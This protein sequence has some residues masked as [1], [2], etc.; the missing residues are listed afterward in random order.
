MFKKLRDRIS[1]EVQQQ[2]LKLPASVQQL[3][4]QS[5]LDLSGRD[6]SAAANNVNL[7]TIDDESPTK[8]F[9]VNVNPKRTG[10]LHDV[11][12]DSTSAGHSPAGWP[13]VSARFHRGSVGSS[14]S[15]IPACSSPLPMGDVPSANFTIPLSDL[16]SASEWEESYAADGITKDRLFQAYSKMRQRYHKYKGRYADVVRAYR[17]KEREA[18]KLRD[19]LAKTQDQTM[20]RISDLRD[21]CALETQAKAHLEE[22]LRGDLE[23]KDHKIQS[24]LTKVRLL[25]E[26]Y[27]LHREEDTSN[28][29]KYDEVMN[30][31]G[32]RGGDA[33]DGTCKSLGSHDSGVA[34]GVWDDP[35]F[36]GPGA[37]D[38][39]GDRRATCL[40][41][42]NVSLGSVSMS[43]A[44]STTGST[45]SQL[46]AEE[47]IEKLKGE[48]SQQKQ[49]LARCMEN[50]RNKRD[51][52]AAVTA[53]RN[54]L[55]AKLAAVQNEHQIELDQLKQT[56]ES[57]ALS[58]AETKQ[59]LF[60]EL[61]RKE[62]QVEELRE[63]CAEL[64]QK[65]DQ[66]PPPRP[67]PDGCSSLPATPVLNADE[68]TA[69][70]EKQAIRLAVGLCPEV[71]PPSS[72]LVAVPSLEHSSLGHPSL[73]HPSLVQPLDENQSLV[74]QTEILPCEEQQSSQT[75]PLPSS[76]DLLTFSEAIDQ[77]SST[78]NDVQTTYVAAIAEL[79]TTKRDLQWRIGEL[80]EK[81]RQSEEL[82][83]Q[84]TDDCAEMETKYSNVQ[85]RNERLQAELDSLNASY[86]EVQGSVNE[87]VKQRSELSN[88]VSCLL[89]E[90][91]LLK[92]TTEQHERSKSES[93][94]LAEQIETLKDSH[95]RLECELLAIKTEREKLQRDLLEAI[96]ERDEIRG[97]ASFTLTCLQELSS[98]LDDELLVGGK[99]LNTE[100]TVDSKREIVYSSEAFDVRQ[101]CDN[102]KQRIHDQHS[103]LEK[104][105]SDKCDA[106]KRVSVLQN[107]C[108]S[109]MAEADSIINDRRELQAK[110][111]HVENEFDS[112]RQRCEVLEEQA[113]KSLEIRSNVEQQITHLNSN[114]KLLEAERSEK[115]AEIEGLREQLEITS[116]NLVDASRKNDELHTIQEN[117]KIVNEALTTEKASLS[118]SLSDVL[119]ER[120]EWKS[121]CTSL[122][123]E[124]D[125]KQRRV[126]ELDKLL[127]QSN[128]ALSVSMEKTDKLS[129]ENDNLNT[130]LIELED[131]HER[132][133][134]STQSA[135]DLE[136]NAELLRAEISQKNSDLSQMEE[137][138]AFRE[139]EISELMSS[140]D[141]LISTKQVLADRIKSLE[142]DLEA[143]KSLELE[144]KHEMNLLNEQLETVTNL[145]T[146]ALDAEGRINELET[147]CA[148]RVADLEQLLND[149]KERTN[150]L[151]DELK[152]SS[153][154]I[155][156]LE[157]ELEILKI[158][159]DSQVV[160]LERL[161]MDSERVAELEQLNNESSARVVE[162]ESELEV[163]K[164][165]SDSRAKELQNELEQANMDSNSKFTELEQLKIESSTRVVELERELEVVKRTSDS[166]VTELQ[167]EL[168]QVKKEMSIS[169]TELD[170]LK[171]NSDSRVAQ[172]E[173]EKERIKHTHDLQ[174]KELEQRLAT[175]DDRL[176]DLGK[177]MQRLKDAHDV[178][179]ADMEQL[180]RTSDLR[181]MEVENQLL[182]CKQEL[183]ASKLELSQKTELLA[184]KEDEWRVD[185]TDLRAK[186]EEKSNEVQ[187]LNQ[188]MD[189]RITD[190]EN[191]VKALLTQHEYLN[192]ELS[193]SKQ[194]VEELRKNLNS[195]EK[196]LTEANSLN[197]SHSDEHRQLLNT[198][199]EKEQLI[200]T[201]REENQNLWT[202]SQA[203]MKAVS[204]ELEQQK[205][206]MQA[207]S[208][209]LEEKILGLETNS[210]EN[211]ALSEHQIASL[212]A[213]VKE[214]EGRLSLQ[215]LE[216]E[217][218][219]QKHAELLQHQDQQLLQQ[220]QLQEQQQVSGAGR[221]SDGVDVSAEQRSQLENTRSS[222]PDIAAMR[223]E[224]LQLKGMIAK[225]E[226]ERENSVK[227]VAMLQFNNEHNKN[228]VFNMELSYAQLSEK[229]KALQEKLDSRDKST[230]ELNYD[231]RVK[232]LE[233][234]HAFDKE[235]VQTQFLELQKK[236]E[237][238]F[239]AEK[240]EL[241]KKYKETVKRL[242]EEVAGLQEIKESYAKQ[243]QQIEENNAAMHGKLSAVQDARDLAR[244]EKQK[245]EDRLSELSKEKDQIQ[246]EFDELSKLKVK[247]EH[248]LNDE[249][250]KVGR[251]D[252]RLVQLTKENNELQS[253]I[254]KLSHCQ[255]TVSG[256]V[257][258]LAKSEE[259]LN[260][261]CELL[262]ENL[263]IAREEAS[264]AEA[265]ST[266]ERDR[267]QDEINRLKDQLEA[268]G[269][270]MS[271][272]QAKEEAM[273]KL[274]TELKLKNE[275]LISRVAEERRSQSEELE[276]L[277]QSLAAK[278]DARASAQ[279]AEESWDEVTADAQT[280]PGDASDVDNA[281]QNSLPSGSEGSVKRDIE[282]LLSHVEG[283]WRTRTAQ[284]V[285]RKEQQLRR[286][287]EQLEQEWNKEKKELERLTGVAAQAFRTG[288]D[289]VE[290]LRQQVEQ[291]RQELQHIKRQHKL[292]VGELRALLE[293]K[294]RGKK[295]D[296]SGTSATAALEDSA[297]FEYLK[298]VLYQY[299]MG[300]ETQTLARVL[301]AVVK[302][303]EQQQ[304]DIASHLQSLTSMRGA[305]SSGSGTD[306]SR[307]TNFSDDS[308]PP[309]IPPKKR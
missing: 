275:D 29:N 161:K 292:E 43:A 233:E 270:Q 263:R 97:A 153:L 269:N 68:E 309:P 298:N 219:Q 212:E 118:S 265:R 259:D 189:Q 185:V 251:L 120:D 98:S 109:L 260:G 252:E 66:P 274:E 215:Q 88:R 156:E 123:N 122:Q 65:L 142:N 99:V 13:P 132:L 102:L 35:S 137:Q 278:Y 262:R 188:E 202:K 198:L 8:D 93:S 141:E 5:L 296:A 126:L 60:E 22:E 283:A 242:E 183:N 229:V 52:V 34:A 12:L 243:V 27:G 155:A 267:M 39:G 216:Y 84:L 48:V 217:Q 41:V 24:L 182:H 11:Q 200:V 40:E 240:A 51:V 31:A 154:R 76:G 112:C 228:K 255:D 140:R 70:L 75:E 1:E 308:K 256:E 303:D 23:E 69:A 271:C 168:E 20:R 224:Q 59:Q 121:K 117:L 273:Q 170:K 232:D 299:M 186:L 147:S 305:R 110:L 124:N 295:S 209:E 86:H 300:R 222:S 220:Q 250:M 277:L 36:P 282:S 6:A 167:K 164:R 47:L 87:H 17:E 159:R 138:A 146:R 79:E 111:E 2:S 71:S 106:E 173:E 214:Y 160:E 57:S 148:T 293:V 114:L 58:M 287:M 28:N 37:Y 247:F 32:G 230:E 139:K 226:E 221:T 115:S 149:S 127:D 213:Q 289:S 191:Q 16:E 151:E 4:Q 55:A 201:L 103:T 258:S 244:A 187:N 129:S 290:L 38:E 33:A 163:L 7:F 172:L 304:Q 85:N 74:G 63:Q 241:E 135:S 276:R 225:Y 89:E 56:I 19:V 266:L 199:S 204:Q 208:R 196:N 53:E 50:I 144:L 64:Q 249:R 145:E 113:T 207:A 9:G 45:Y 62:E 184:K 231:Q 107:Q 136:Q 130:R 104:L 301:C 237:E 162:L 78:S 238:V 128:S 105:Q 25:Q 174:V 253:K 175:S 264:T 281:A 179:L 158:T 116:Q 193:T 119:T 46:Q 284:L 285:L 236:S 101:Y 108:D 181:V 83:R 54:G 171:L 239:L 125:E 254:R 306:A 190:H 80:E 3:T 152:N 197:S 302:F 82:V 307:S 294:K 92:E 49:L 96:S 246:R 210:A 227:L 134:N 203:R 218:V 165:T 72:L 133:R 94:K 95:N 178:C 42:D 18:E 67:A 169:T 14:T 177:E 268:Q 286:E 280:A 248:E 194:T 150:K 73:E 288:K 15:D 166:R 100:R 192:E 180:K 291:Q 157:N 143:S 21:Q 206:L 30:S 77:K 131:M 90:I 261:E 279:A 245:L 223:A 234:R 195:I 297:E 44:V 235:K 272:L 10:G 81:N 61:Q 205:A 211:E 257:Q 176:Q 26:G 91:Q